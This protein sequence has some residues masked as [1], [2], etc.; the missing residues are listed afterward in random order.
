NIDV[1]VYFKMDEAPHEM[2]DS[3]QIEK[4]NNYKNKLS[5]KGVYFWE[6]KGLSNYK[7]YLSQ[8]LALLVQR[9]YWSK[10]KQSVKLINDF[11][12]DP[13][14]LATDNYNQALLYRKEVN[15]IILML[16]LYHQQ[17][18]EEINGEN[19]KIN[20][21]LKLS[22]SHKAFNEIRKV[23]DKSTLRIIEQNKNLEK[24]IS[25]FKYSFLKMFSS[26]SNAVLMN[27]ELKKKTRE[28]LLTSILSLVELITGYENIKSETEKSIKL[29][30]T[31]LKDCRFPA[32]NRALR[33]YL[34]TKNIYRDMFIDS[35]YM[36]KELEKV[37]R[38]II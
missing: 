21:L 33:K 36:I 18:A 25:D 34:R 27:E 2:I 11:K 5:E 37:T 26:Y 7:N 29:H 15:E 32:Y 35:I 8:H 22:S 24:E 12:N 9:K 30:E 17:E 14:K 20:S 13:I 31:E 23:F 4:L 38:K 28:Q 16:A 1:M 3:C 10:D 19:E 6:F